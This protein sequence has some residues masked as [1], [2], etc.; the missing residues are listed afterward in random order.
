MLP[1]SY[2]DLGGAEQE[3]TEGD[4][5]PI[6]GIRDP[7]GRLPYPRRL[8]TGRPLV[9][10]GYEKHLPAFTTPWVPYDEVSMLMPMHITGPIKKS[11]TCNPPA[12]Y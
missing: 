8:R 7:D 1:C 11:R 3:T 9:M 6:L 5:R 4:C 10:N 12:F 2:N